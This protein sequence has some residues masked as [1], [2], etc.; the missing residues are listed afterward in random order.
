MIL[1]AKAA[2]IRGETGDWCI[3][4]EHE[5]IEFDLREVIRKY[6]TRPVRMLMTEPIVLLVSLYM[7]FVY[8]ILYAFL[9]A[10]PYIFEGEYGMSPGVAGLPLIAVIMGVAAAVGFVI[11]QRRRMIK[12]A[13]AKGVGPDPEVHLLPPIV[14]AFVFAAALFWYVNLSCSTTKTS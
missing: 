14:G 12:R 1:T 2:K 10:Y 4:A 13:F 9:E 6:F 5:R 11:W 8:G 3:H 7:S